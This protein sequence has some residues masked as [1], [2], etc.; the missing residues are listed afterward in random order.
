METKSVKCFEAIER[1]TSVEE[2]LLDTNKHQGFE[3]M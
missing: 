3:S 2:E 1:Q